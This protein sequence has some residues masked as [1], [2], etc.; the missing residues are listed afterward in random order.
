ME[1][2]SSGSPGT[3][4]PGLWRKWLPEAPDKPAHSHVDSFLTAARLLR[5]GGRVEEEGKTVGW[6][7]SRRSNQTRETRPDGNQ[8]PKHA[9]VFLK[10]LRSRQVHLTE[11]RR[12]D[13]ESGCEKTNTGE[14]KD[15]DEGPFSGHG[16]T[17][18]QKDIVVCIWKS[19]C[20][21][22]CRQSTRFKAPVLPAIAEI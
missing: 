15:T 2:R 9:M 6:Q 5:G 8:G 12:E 22:K 3:V 16:Q 4:A 19:G 20:R 17:E 18:R 21:V 7:S 13:R 11:N 10:D 14:E 1:V